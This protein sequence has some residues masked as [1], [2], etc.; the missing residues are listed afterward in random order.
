MALDED[1]W[2]YEG[3][4][5]ATGFITLGSGVISGSGAAFYACAFEHCAGAVCVGVVWGF[6]A[7]GAL[8]FGECSGKSGISGIA[9]SDGG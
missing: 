5:S 9:L 7:N 3:S 2:G 8:D 6:H 4:G 1:G